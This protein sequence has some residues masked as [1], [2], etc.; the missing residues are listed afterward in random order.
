M[1]AEQHRHPDPQ[2]PRPPG[3]GGKQEGRGAKL[4]GVVGR[5][6]E[7]DG[8]PRKTVEQPGLVPPEALGEEAGGWRPAT[9]SVLWL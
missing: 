6:G 2:T 3:A 1:D 9:C 4:K 7:E 5:K 8:K